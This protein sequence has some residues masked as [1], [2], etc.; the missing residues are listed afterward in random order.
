MR[1]ES[2][3]QIPARLDPA[4]L[5]AHPELAT[6]ALELP[7]SDGEPVENERERFHMNLVLDVLSQHWHD[8]QDF[9]AAGKPSGRMLTPPKPKSPGC[10]LNSPGSRQRTAVSSRDLAS[11]GR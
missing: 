6:L 5:E 9:Y 1:H 10:G 4:L 7:D 11:Y 2:T 8:R 3:V